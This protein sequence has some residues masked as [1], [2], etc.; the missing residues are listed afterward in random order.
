MN[1]TIEGRRLLVKHNEV[2]KR[3]KIVDDEDQPE[4]AV[5]LIDYGEIVLVNYDDFYTCEGLSV[6]E[7]LKSLQLVFELPPQCFECRLS[8][9]IPSPILCAAGWSENSTEAFKKFIEGS[10][11]EIFV[12]SFVNKIA[13]VRLSVASEAGIQIV[14]DYLVWEGFAQSSDDSY[15][16]QLNHLERERPVHRHNREVEKVEDEF[17]DVGVVPPPEDMLCETVKIEGPFSPLESRLEMITRVKCIDVV[18]EASSVNQVLIDPFPNDAIKKVL[19]SASMSKRDD[20]VTLQQTTILP[21]LPGMMSLLALIFSPAA[22]VHVTTK[23]D[24]YTTILCGLGADAQR[25]PHFG[26]HDSL[27]QVDVELNSNDFKMINELREMI[28]KLLRN[29]EHFKF[30]PKVNTVNRTPLRRKICQLLLQI[31]STR[32]SSLGTLVPN[33]Y[34]WNWKS[35]DEKKE[36]LRSMYPRLAQVEKL[37]PMSKETRDRK[38]RRADELKQRSKFNAQDEVIECS[39]CEERIETLVDLKLHVEKKLHKD[40]LVRIRDE[41]SSAF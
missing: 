30:Q 22:E 41:T 3:G 24:R 14:N 15:M 27:V 4:F 40:R 25:I 28:S 2:L 8:E 34:E 13:S 35:L 10:D 7:R 39:L 21:H 26:E 6:D 38:I 37:L 31:A 5:Y 33:D 17:C 12:N 16:N 1:E 20:R 32:R 36:I 18:V 9:V 29:V 11:L 19:V 23:K